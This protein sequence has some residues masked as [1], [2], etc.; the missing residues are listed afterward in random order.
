MARWPAARW[1]P[2]TT[3]GPGSIKPIA[4]C[5]HHQVGTGDPAGVYQA[6][7]V[8]AH[9]WLPRAGQPVQH[10]DTNVSSW[11]GGT[12]AHNTNAIGVETEGCGSAP[13]ADP[14]TEHQLTT[15]GQLMAWANAT[16]GIPLVLSE[17]ASSPGLNYHRCPGGFATA[18]PCDV[19]LNARPE[20]LRRAGAGA[21][22]QED[23][24]MPSLDEIRQ[25]IRQ[26]FTI[27]PHRQVVYEEARKAALEL[28]R[29]EEYRQIL[30]RANQQ[31]C[32]AGG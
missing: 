23:D 8:S 25:M 5:L 30:V 20:I 29:S 3:C 31:G 9:F 27:N 17:S 14:L 11:H 21:P 22:P 12:A 24:D 1:N 10:V 6:R 26:E 2:V 15:F 13:H 7:N 16:H 4:V 18:C 28:M 32:K 19:R